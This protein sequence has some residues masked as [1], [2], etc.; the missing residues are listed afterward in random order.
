MQKI[1][2]FIKENKEDKKEI[3]ISYEMSK[4]VE[5]FKEFKKENIEQNITGNYYC[6]ILKLD[7][8]DIKVYSNILLEYDEIEFK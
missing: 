3:H 8:E 4:M 7:N 1:L 6:G 5:N 2:D